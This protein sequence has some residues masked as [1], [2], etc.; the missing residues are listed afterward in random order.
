MC[1]I[2]LGSH[3]HYYINQNYFIPKPKSESVNTFFQF[4]ALYFTKSILIYLRSIV[5]LYDCQKEKIMLVIMVTVQY[6]QYL[7]RGLFWARIEMFM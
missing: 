3:F 1:N 5:S 7:L 4:S 2:I 6:D